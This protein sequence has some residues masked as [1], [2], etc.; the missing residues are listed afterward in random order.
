MFDKISP[1]FQKHPPEVFCRKGVLRNF[2]KFAGKHLCQSLFLIRFIE[3]E[4]LAQVFYYELCEISKNIFFH[5]TPPDGCFWAF[6]LN[7]TLLLKGALRWKIFISPEKLFS[8]WRCLNFCSNFF[9]H[10]EKW[11]DKP[12]LMS[13]VVTSQT[14]KQ[15]QYTYCPI[16]HNVKATGQWTLNSS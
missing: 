9:G 1:S 16:T 7:L 12:R 5:G 8:F 15:L 14:G 11:L 4:T 13:E 6:S 3:K 2:A 10:V